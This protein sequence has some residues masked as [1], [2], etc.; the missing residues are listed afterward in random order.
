MKTNMIN[1]LLT[2]IIAVNL[3]CSE[4]EDCHLIKSTDTIS[5]E[6]MKQD[7]E[8]TLQKLESIHPLT[9]NGCSDEQKEII[10]DIR[11]EIKKPLKKREFEFLI[12]RLFYT[13]HDA[14]TNLWFDWRTGISLPILWLKNGMFILKFNDN[15]KY[16]KYFIHNRFTNLQTSNFQNG[17]KII[18]IGDKSVEC[19][20]NELK[21]IICT[22]NYSFIKLMGQDVLISRSYLDFY[23]LIHNDSVKITIERNHEIIETKIPVVKLGQRLKD[24]K[25]IEYSIDNIND[26]AILNLKQCIFDST[27]K[28]TLRKF[29]KE[30][31]E[32][33][34]NNVILDLRVNDG[35]D[36]QV[37]AE[38]IRY[39]DIDDFIW[40]GANVRYSPDVRAITK[41]SEFGYKHFPPYL[42][43]NNR[44][45][46][47]LV[48]KGNLF[49]LTNK[50]TFSSAN[51]FAVIIKD[52][53]I[54]KIVGESTGNKPTCYGNPLNFMMPNSEIYF[55]VS[56]KEFLRPNSKANS[57]DSLYPDIEVYTTIDDVINDKDTQLEKIV[58]LLR[59]KE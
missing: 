8:F 22:E 54:G 35:G 9:V 47:E 52:N 57:E 20:I 12:N 53:N 32:N 51:M 17:D 59:N 34:I 13:F 3:N 41:E 30:A 6:M 42:F 15:S 48:F 45:S 23:N 16:Y 2:V 31:N 37:V 27:Y 40:Y 38:F 29:F 58:E 33:N 4:Q 28:A 1:I 49:V 10:K 24:K 26:F 19:I 5:V 36:S 44:V 56:I 43:K 39:F 18:S 11:K 25:W 46:A 14:H 21:Q 7:F 55:R 50:N